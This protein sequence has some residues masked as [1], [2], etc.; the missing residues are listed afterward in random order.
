VL[1][2][3]GTASLSRLPRHIGERETGEAARE[4]GWEPGCF[5]IREVD[6]L[7]PG[8]AVLLEIESGQITEVA[9]AVGERGVPAEDVARRAAREMKRYQDAGVPVGEHLADQLL[10]L[11]A[12]AGSGAFATLPL[13]SHSRTQIDLIPRFLDVRIDV[14][15]IE[16]PGDGRHILCRVA[17]RVSSMNCGSP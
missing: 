5:E 15:P 12:L 14:I 3:R 9:S 4:T 8:N 10:L 1:R 13:T 2:R 17:S 11:L 16:E 7:G 6:A